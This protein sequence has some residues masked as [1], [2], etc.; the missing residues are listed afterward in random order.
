MDTKSLFRADLHTHT[1]CSDGS[2]AP[3]QLLALAKTTGL[4]GLSITDHDT[5]DGYDQISDLQ[6]GNGTF[7]L[8]T[9]VEL[10]CRFEGHSIHI[11]GYDFSLTHPAIRQ[12]CAW[13]K[14]RRGRRNRAMLAKL[15]Q[16]K[17]AITEEE[18]GGTS[19]LIGRV[20]IAKKMVEKG[21][22]PSIKE[23][24]MR[25]LGEEKICY[26]AGEFGSVPDAVN[27]IH[28][29][30]GKAFLAHPHLLPKMRWGK[31]LVALGLDGIECYYGNFSKEQARRWLDLAKEKNLLVS[32]GSDFHGENR[33]FSLLGSS[34]VDEASFH[35]VFSCPLHLSL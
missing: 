4:G 10:S 21:Y 23:A 19:D 27:V 12:L 28:Q 1:T 33:A 18:L 29:A 11:L 31:K 5:I 35:K 15:S 6:T 16:Q 2:F 13:Q 17:M 14:E 3:R 22:V 8:G 34:W 25:Y 24:F 20:H 7:L 26:V 30:G 32:G 9:G